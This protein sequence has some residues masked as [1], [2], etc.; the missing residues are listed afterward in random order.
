MCYCCYR[1]ALL[2]LCVEMCVV[3][4]CNVCALWL[5]WCPFV[6]LCV[7]VRCLVVATLVCVI[8]CYMCASWLFFQLFVVDVCHCCSVLRS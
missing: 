5:Y 2:M 1:C 7:I 8:G 4:C 3:D 6:V